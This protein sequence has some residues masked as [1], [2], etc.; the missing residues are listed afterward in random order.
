MLR[1]ATSDGG[2][3]NSSPGEWFRDRCGR[4]RTCTVSTLTE[5]NRPVSAQ[6]FGSGHFRYWLECH[7]V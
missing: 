2:Y 3:D 6:S 7:V 4:V 5:L 1:A